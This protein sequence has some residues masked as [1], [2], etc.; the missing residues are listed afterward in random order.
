MTDLGRLYVVATPIG[1]LEDLGA[2]ALRV[3]GEV[4]AIVAEDSRR[5]AV[6]LDR[7]GLRKPLLPLHLHSPPAQLRRLVRR[8]QKGESL[9]L[10]S[11]AGT[12][13]L[14]DPGA[15]LVAA[16]RGAGAECLA[17]PG[18]ASPV[19]ALSVSGFRGDNF[20]FFGWPPRAGKERE[21]W[22]DEVLSTPHTALLLEAPHRLRALL[23]EL[24]G[25]E[26]TRRAALCRE[27]T[28]LH[29]QTRVGALAE[30]A[31]SEVEPRGEYVLVLQGRR[32]DAADALDAKPLLRELL[33][34][35]PPSRAAAAAARLTGRRRAELYRLARELAGGQGDAG[36]AGD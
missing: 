16:A 10:V 34:L 15:E 8:L 7:H 9:A 11:D 4:D 12:P 26:G 19:A 13:G 3:L 6:L 33:R 20:V 5:T 35:A 25:R 22:L 32:P 14:C 17:V 21:R 1:N 28:K 36:D 31:A 23:G 27:L 30:L 29:E 18:P 2:R 24:A